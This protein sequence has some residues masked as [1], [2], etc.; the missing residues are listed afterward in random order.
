MSKNKNDVIAIKKLAHNSERNIQNN[1]SEI[2]FL[3]ACKGH[4]NVVLYHKS[5]LM[6]DDEVWLITEYLHGGTLQEA[7]RAHRF[8]DRHV[9]YVAREICA[10][11]NFMHARKF[12]HR[13][14]KSQNIMMAINGAIKL[15]DFGLCADFADGPRVSM[16]G[17]PYWVPPE[18]IKKDPH[19][20]AV[21]IWS[22]GVCLLELYLMEPPYAA[23]AIQCMFAAATTGLASQIP[24]DATPQAK[25]FLVRCLE[26][27]P[28]KRATPAEL[29]ENPWVTR[30]GLSKGIEEVLRDIFLTSTLSSLGF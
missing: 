3:K 24:S 14:L 10:A 28:A 8:E 5:F 18:M 30:S 12:A 27:D 26:V 2:G 11:L 7:A 16:V 21:D 29:M 23:S 13:D 15:I 20:C 6:E 19:A 22:F 1:L 9:A 17:S 4:P 25:A